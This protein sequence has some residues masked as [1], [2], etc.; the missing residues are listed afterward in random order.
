MRIA[1]ICPDCATYI[2]AECIIYNGEYLSTLDVA[3]LTSLDEILLNVNNSFSALS[4]SSTPSTIPTH[5]GQLYLQT[6]GPILWIG[7]GT[8]SINW[9]SLGIISTTTTTTTTP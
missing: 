1:E 5:I 9:G 7:L 6:T 3:P 2:N 4:G 8:S